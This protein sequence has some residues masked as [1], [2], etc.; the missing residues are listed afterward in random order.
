MLRNKQTWVIMEFYKNSF[1]VMKFVRVEIFFVE[2][3]L[4]IILSFRNLKTEV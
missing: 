4:M 2:T 1:I 3:L